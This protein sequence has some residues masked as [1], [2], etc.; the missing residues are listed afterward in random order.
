MRSPHCDAATRVYIAWHLLRP[1]DGEDIAAFLAELSRT[2]WV[3][4]GQIRATYRRIYPERRELVVPGMLPGLARRHMAGI[5]A[6]L[7]AP[8]RVVNGGEDD[9]GAGDESDDDAVDFEEVH[10]HLCGLINN[11]DLLNPIS[12][13]HDQLTETLHEHSIPT[14]RSQQP[15][16]SL[17]KTCHL[18]AAN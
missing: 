2:A 7:P 6:F 9:D 3:E 13:L 12:N 1:D 18:I 8:D 16:T 11:T 10:E 4:P 5:L 17:N 15:Y 14:N